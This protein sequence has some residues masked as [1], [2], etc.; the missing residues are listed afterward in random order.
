[1][2]E[3]LRPGV[4]TERVDAS[5]PGIAAIRTDIA[6]FIG[7]ARS[8]PLDT[9]V[10]VQSFRQF[11]AHFGDFTGQGYLAYAVRGFFE[12]GGRRCW[13]IRVASKHAAHGARAAA[14][15]IVSP[16]GPVWEIAA[17]NPGCWGNQ[18][19]VALQ[20]QRP[21]QTELEPGAS[22]PHY[23]V[24]ASI[25]GFS[26]G[27][28]V[29]LS[30]AGA[31]TQLR[32]VSAVDAAAR[33]LYWVNPNAAAALPYDQALQGFDPNRPVTAESILYRLLVF[34][35]GRLLT[36]FSGLSLIPEHPGYAPA[37]LAAAVYP[38]RVGSHD[39]L[40]APPAPVTVREARA[41]LQAIPDLPDF[42]EGA[43]LA[44]SGGRDGLAHLTVYDFIGERV[45]P[46]DSD[47]VRARKTRGIQAL[48][49]V[50]EIA[51]TAV[52]DIVIQPKPEPVYAPEPPPPVE[53]CLKCPPPPQPVQAFE[54]RPRA[55]ELP[56]VFSDDQIHQVQATLLEHCEQRCDRV[57]VLDP[58]F[59][60]SQ[61]DSAGLGA[62]LAWRERFDSA[63]AALYYP[64]LHVLDP[65]G[66]VVRAIPP[67][68]HAIGQY[69]DA[70]LTVGVHKAAANRKLEWVQ[71][72][73]APVGAGRHEVLNPLGINA[74]R[75]E[76]GRGIRI[77]GARTLSS[78]PDWRYINVRR[79]LLMIRKAIDL[80][81]QW[82]VFEP[83]DDTTRNKLAMSLR[84]FLTAVWQQGALVGAAPDQAFFVKCDRDNNPPEQ[85]DKGRLQADVGVAPSKPFEFVVLR[86]GRQGNELEITESV[87][88]ARAA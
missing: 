68:G 88:L 32:V 40:P 13:V 79:L 60:A 58:P 16:A 46:L 69:A 27:S 67:S 78:D 22:R 65:R 70:D 61:N 64:W 62:I 44:L 28:L 45:S 8:G 43:R 5:A 9:P 30:Q 75:A 86:V 71:A 15:S 1:M 57:A 56:P 82:A 63:Y 73:S 48:D 49:R 66:T 83:N 25:A 19:S 10:P 84:G 39:Q 54:P 50:D 42:V 23:G 72:L 55:E 24:I 33:R 47:V 81:T 38:V 4:Y 20:T 34:R 3:R 17:A 77:M 59:A 51:I 87:L 6:G 76:P 80:A 21:A 74:I 29:R 35:E 14:L 37:V 12:N 53:P 11:Q 52:P 18:L 85:R 31:A 2:P 36:H 26:R 7:I 41:E